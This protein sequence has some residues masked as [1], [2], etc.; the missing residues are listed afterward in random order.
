MYT[1]IYTHTCTHITHTH[2]HACTTLSHRENT[3]RGMVELVL[4]AIIHTHVHTYTHIHTQI[5]TYVHTHTLHTHTHTHT[6]THIHTH[7]YI[8]SHLTEDM[9]CYGGV[10]VESYNTNFRRLHINNTINLLL[11]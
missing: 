9:S 1:H 5:L 6:H 2:T 3:R 7:T 4:R 10:G 8:L 11:I